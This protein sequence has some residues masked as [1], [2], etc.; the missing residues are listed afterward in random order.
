MEFSHPVSQD[1]EVLI[2]ANDQI[3]K[4]QLYKK[5]GDVFQPVGEEQTIDPAAES[6]AVQIPAEAEAGVEAYYIKVFRN[7]ADVT[8]APADIDIADTNEFTIN[9]YTNTIEVYKKDTNGNLLAGA[10]FILTPFN[11]GDAMEVAYEATSDANGKAVF[12]NVEVGPYLLS[13]IEAPDGY[14]KSDEVYQLNVYENG[15]FVLNEEYPNGTEYS[16]VT[17]VNEKEEEQEVT[18]EIPFTK[19]VKQTGEKAPA[20]QNFTFEVYGFECGDVEDKIVVS[21]NVIETNGKGT[22]DGNIKLTF[23]P[24]EVNESELLL[25][26]FYVREKKENVDGWT[27][28]DEVWYVYRYPQCDWS[29]CKVADGEPQ[30][31]Y[32][33]DK[34]SFTNSYKVFEVKAPAGTPADKAVVKS[35]EKAPEKSVD[36]SA[37]ALQTGDKG[38]EILWLVL[39]AVSGLAVVYYIKKKEI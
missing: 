27:Y 9:W 5:V 37:K 14:I 10:T 39:L 23:L 26:G 35:D 21:G 2:T 25:S 28:S 3:S 12:R 32:P 6:A 1:A 13:E 36:K 19:I 34:M 7:V 30:Y 38:N 15:V 4:Y 17:F 11:Q 20:K 29:F 31:N 8:S 16:P 24:S 22:Y 18:V 33:Q